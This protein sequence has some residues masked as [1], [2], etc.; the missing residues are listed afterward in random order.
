MG[1]LTE[2][3]MKAPPPPKG[4]DFSMPMMKGWVPRRLQPWIYVLTALCFQFSGGMYLGALDEIRGTTNFMIEDV[5]F[6]LYSSLA[7][8]AVWFPMLFK[9][10]FRFTNQQLLCTSAIVIGICNIITMHSHSMPV[11]VVVCFFAGIAKIQGT[12]ECMSNIQ[13]WITPRRDFA[14][15]FPVLHIILLTAIEG[16]GWLAAWIGYHFT[17]EMMHVITVGTM[18]FVLLTQITLCRPFCPMPNRLSL[19]GTDWQGA[20]LICI[21]MLLFSYIFV[22]GDYHRWFE[23]QYIRM[24]GAFAL[25]FA[26][27][28]LYRLISNRYPYVELRLLKCKNVVPILIV[29]TLAELAFGAEH[30]VEEIIYTEVVGLE[31]LTKEYQYMWALPG[32][33][34]GIA[35]D[36]YWLKLQKWK[37]WKLIGIAF[38]SVFAYALL[39]YLTVG[40]SVNIEQYRLAILLRGFGYGILV[41]TLMWA[42]NESVP[43]LEQF[44]MGL[45]VF[46][47]VHMYLGGA[48]GYGFYTTFISYFLTED[49]MNYGRQLTLTNLDLSHFIFGELCCVSPENSR[50]S[51]LAFGRFMGDSYLH[52]MMLVAIK[53]VYGYVIWY[54]LILSSIFLLC[55]IPAVRT[56]IRRVPLWPVFAIEYLAGRRK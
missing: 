8:M 2:F 53:Q 46:N 29:T 34:F 36:I 54:S 18:S 20:L 12:F 56:N 35:F 23:S 55:D 30:T 15:F 47:I 49:M 3:L 24:A 52:S 5:M 39:M 4:L 28:A 11:L 27:L 40:V 32:M 9:M 42:L 1:R 48:M 45:F 33:F 31:E 43:I 21:T 19:K 41:P 22:Y 13:L 51:Q 14:V 38:L 6:L 37:V 7:G 25:I 50:C 44:F 16:G 17:W 26:G 10:K